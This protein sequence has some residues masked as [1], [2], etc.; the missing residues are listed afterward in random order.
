M[1]RSADRHAQSTKPPSNP[2]RSEQRRIEAPLPWEAH[3]ID[4]PARQAKLGVGRR[5]EPRPSI[6][7]LGHAQRWGGPSERRLQEAERVL[8]VE[9]S[10]I[11]APSELQVDLAGSGPPEP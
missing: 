7:L 5:D 8:D 6:S 4:K 9:A 10:K 1:R 3:V 11:R 2:R